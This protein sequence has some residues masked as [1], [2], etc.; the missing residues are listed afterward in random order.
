MSHLF[1]AWSSIG[2][3]KAVAEQLNYND[4]PL[5]ISELFHMF[6]SAGIEQHWFPKLYNSNLPKRK[7]R[8]VSNIR[9]R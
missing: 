4:C 8:A 7:T 9:H 3:E 2:I 1:T 6:E 5:N